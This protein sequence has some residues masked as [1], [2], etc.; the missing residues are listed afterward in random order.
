MPFLTEQVERLAIAP[1]QAIREVRDILRLL[2]LGEP[3]Q[4]HHDV[5]P[6]IH[7]HVGHE[8]SGG[9]FQRQIR[10]PAP[11]HIDRQPAIGRPIRARFETPPHINGIEYRDRDAR[12]NQLLSKPGCGRGFARSPLPDDKNR[13]G[14]GGEG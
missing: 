3:A 7:N 8:R 2:A 10:M 12:M 9:R 6:L 14:R 5:D 13:F 11:E 4:A 1:V